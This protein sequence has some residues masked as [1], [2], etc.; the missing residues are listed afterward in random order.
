MEIKEE[1]IICQNAHGNYW[2]L[3]KTND[4]NFIFTHKG[5]NYKK[6]DNADEWN[7]EK[8]C[9]CLEDAESLRRSVFNHYKFTKKQNTF[10]FIK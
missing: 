8:G 6:L 4:I 9:Y 2:V 5:I 1:F 10:K 3:Q 7:C